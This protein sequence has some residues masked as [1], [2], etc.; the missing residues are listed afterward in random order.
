MNLTNKKILTLLKEKGFKLTSQRKVVLEAI[1]TSH[2]R[3]TSDDVYDLIHK[4]HPKIGLVTIYRTL[5]ILTESGL[6][7]EVHT[8]KRRSYIIRRP[9]EHHHHLVCTQCGMVVD[10]AGCDL[11]N[12]EA[13]L[14]NETGFKIE[15]HLLEFSGYC[16]NCLKETNINM[17]KEVY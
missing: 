9:T 12:L 17:S 3:F 2:E 4:K 10:F 8:G 1:M 16:L 14:S 5:N 6:I 15:G 7:C 13:R 11:S